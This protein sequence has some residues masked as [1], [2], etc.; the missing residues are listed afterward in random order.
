M[1]AAEGCGGS[2]D[3]AAGEAP[4]PAGLACIQMIGGPGT[5]TIIRILNSQPDWGHTPPG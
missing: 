5:T 4:Q 1:A 3:D 2:R